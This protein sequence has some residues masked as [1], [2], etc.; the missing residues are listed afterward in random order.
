MGRSRNYLL[1]EGAGAYGDDHRQ[2]EGLPDGVP[3]AISE[4]ASL[5]KV[6]HG[7]LKAMSRL[8]KREK[9]VR[10]FGLM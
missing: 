3:A 10:V 2:E 6:V 7:T 8:P 9:L 4:V 1:R 5:R